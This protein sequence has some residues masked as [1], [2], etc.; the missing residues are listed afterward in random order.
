VIRLL[1]SWYGQIWPNLVADLVGLPAAF[2]WSHRRQARKFAAQLAEH[3]AS[4]A[5]HITTTAA[6]P[7]QDGDPRV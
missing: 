7:P 2:I 1:W 5:E 4:L 3:H 6:S